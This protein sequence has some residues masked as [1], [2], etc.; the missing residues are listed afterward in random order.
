MTPIER[1]FTK[2]VDFP[3]ILSKHAT[4]FNQN[5][6]FLVLYWIFPEPPIPVPNMDKGKGRRFWE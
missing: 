1:G 6:T 4:S 2:Q 5:Q 3:H